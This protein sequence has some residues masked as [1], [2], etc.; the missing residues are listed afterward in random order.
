MVSCCTALL[1]LTG[2]TWRSCVTS[3]RPRC[4]RKHPSPSAP[5]ASRPSLSRLVVRRVA[6]ACS[7][8]SL[9]RYSRSSS[10]HCCLY[11]SKSSGSKRTII[12]SSPDSS[13]SPRLRC[14]RRNRV[15]IQFLILLVARSSPFWR[16]TWREPHKISR[17]RPG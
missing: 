4:A 16:L 9:C 14:K 5:A 10:P 8:S 3:R 17:I 7:Q 12:V 11:A 15:T 2:E 1:T 6:V 13:R